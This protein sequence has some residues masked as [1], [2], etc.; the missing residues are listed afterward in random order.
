M[1][2]GRD[3]GFV[4]GDGVSSLLSVVAESPV[5]GVVPGC[6]PDNCCRS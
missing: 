3:F 1:R 4:I 5:A 6:D 2:T